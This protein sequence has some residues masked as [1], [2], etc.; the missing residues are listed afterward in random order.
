MENFI[1][2]FGVEMI[3]EISASA[4]VSGLFCYESHPEVRSIRAALNVHRIYAV[5][6]A[7][8]TG[9]RGEVIFN[10]NSAIMKSSFSDLS[11]NAPCL[12]EL[13]FEI[14]LLNPIGVRAGSSLKADAQGGGLTFSPVTFEPVL[15]TVAAAAISVLEA[16]LQQVTQIRGDAPRSRGRNRLSL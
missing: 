15:N 14:E 12:P 8:W 9:F 2:A 1:A 16:T 4:G 6:T 3:I 5:Q 7:I 10:P 13:R 11:Q